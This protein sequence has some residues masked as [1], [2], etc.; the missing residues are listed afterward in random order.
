MLSYTYTLTC[1]HAHIHTTCLCI[2]PLIMRSSDVWIN[3]SLIKEIQVT[4]TF[5][6]SNLVVVASKCMHTNMILK[7]DKHTVM[8]MKH[9]Y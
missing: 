1:I 3:V 8:F 9:V 6:V 5:N 2:V 4:I 7:N